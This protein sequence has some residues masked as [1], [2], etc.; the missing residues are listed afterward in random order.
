MLACQEGSVVGEDFFTDRTF[1]TSIIDSVTIE[2]STIIYDS[3]PTGNLGRLMIGNYQDSILGLITAHTVFEVGLDNGVNYV[4]DEELTEYDSV[5]LWFQS[6]GFFYHNTEDSKSSVEVR[7]LTQDIAEDE[8][9]GFFNTSFRNIDSFLSN[10]TI[11][12]TTFRSSTDRFD[13][14]FVRLDDGLG[15]E[16][17]NRAISNDEAFTSETEFREFIKGFLLSPVGD[18]PF[19]GFNEDVQLRLYYRDFEFQPLILN[20]E[21]TFSLGANTYYNRVTNDKEGTI[22]S[23]L[24]TLEEPLKSDDTNNHLIMQGGAGYA[25][26]IELPYLRDFVLEDQNYLIA[27]ATLEIPVI[28]NTYEE[29]SY[30]PET[31]ESV[32]VDENNLD[33]VNVQMRDAILTL[34]GDFQ[35]DTKYEVDILNF[36]ETQLTIR[37][38]NENAI[39]LR[40]P[41]PEM[42]TSTV[43]AILGDQSEGMKVIIHTI[44][45]NNE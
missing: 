10:P 9:D 27:A 39:V 11:G 17:Y 42:N 15:R 22:F 30:L 25:I 38:N 19:L 24:Q 3:L 34:D 37:E 8:E 16:I 12:A 41:Y 35:R 13:S 14:L 2:A 29:G 4:L 28:D 5:G 43:R 32:F 7:Q 20:R 1:E 23:D 36:I 26:R 21:M 44:S 40:M 45:N 6:D 31:M 33:N 18:V